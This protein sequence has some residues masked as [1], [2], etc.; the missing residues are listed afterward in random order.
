[1]T[2]NGKLIEKFVFNRIS[3]KLLKVRVKYGIILLYKIILRGIT[4]EKLF[5]SIEHTAS[6]VR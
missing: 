3:V 6:E 5:L 4:Y 1:M 2:V